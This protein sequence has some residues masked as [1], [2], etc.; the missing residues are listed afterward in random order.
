MHVVILLKYIKIFLKVIFLKL[1]TCYL[2]SIFTFQMAKAR[3]IP[4]VKENLWEVP[5]ILI[6]NSSLLGF[7][8]LIPKKNSISEVNDG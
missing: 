3:V 2:F 8:F 1:G 5:Y 6:S 7:I 4:S